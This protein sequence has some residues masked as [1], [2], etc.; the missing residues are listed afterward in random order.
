MLRAA[1]LCVVD[2]GGVGQKE[3]GVLRFGAGAAAAEGPE[4]GVEVHDGAG[5]FVAGL[6][7]EAHST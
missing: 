3:D 7:V 1:V 6:V 4:V 2:G 5:V